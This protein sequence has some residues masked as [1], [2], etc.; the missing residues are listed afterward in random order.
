[1]SKYKEFIIK[2]Y[3]KIKIN[4]VNKIQ[5]KN[6]TFSVVDDILRFFKHL[7]MKYKENIDVNN[8]KR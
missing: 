7:R 6:T 2:I 3:S 1:M 5:E 8:I 4:L